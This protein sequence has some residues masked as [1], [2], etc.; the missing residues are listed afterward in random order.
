MTFVFFSY[1][2]LDVFVS[3]L[4]FFIR[5][6]FVFCEVGVFESRWVVFSSGGG[7]VKFCRYGL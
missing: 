1:S 7:G 6:R 4:V 5:F 2:V 3:V